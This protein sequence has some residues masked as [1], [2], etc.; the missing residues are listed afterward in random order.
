MGE[1]KK[2]YT[3]EIKQDTGS[4]FIIGDNRFIEDFIKYN[5]FCFLSGTEFIVKEGVPEGWH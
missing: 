5:R 1:G 3:L 4:V 2:E